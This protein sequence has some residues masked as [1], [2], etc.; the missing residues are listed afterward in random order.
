MAIGIPKPN[1]A[2]IA[3]ADGTERFTGA[4]A[5]WAT[6]LWHASAEGTEQP[7]ALTCYG[8]GLSLPVY[9]DVLIPRGL[10]GRL[11]VILG[12]RALLTAR[13]TSMVIPC[14]SRPIEEI[15][16]SPWASPRFWHVMNSM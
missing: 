2:Q 12:C 14:L 9:S 6:Q 5:C 4:L 13:M 10:I 1:C 15:S 11:S 7:Q 3:R 8:D 16:I